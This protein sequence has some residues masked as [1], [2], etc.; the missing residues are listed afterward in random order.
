[1]AT[2]DFMLSTCTFMVFKIN[3]QRFLNKGKLFTKTISAKNN[4]IP[5]TVKSAKFVFQP[6][7]KNKTNRQSNKI[8]R[9]YKIMKFGWKLQLTL[10]I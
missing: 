1:M 9:Q 3:Q 5:C 8:K 4:C 6:I 10:S 7:N 2:Q